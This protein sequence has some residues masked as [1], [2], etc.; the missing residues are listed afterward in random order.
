MYIVA[1]GFLAWAWVNVKK[2]LPRSIIPL[3]A[4]ISSLLL[5]VQIFEFPVAGGGS[6]WHFLGG[7]TVSM[8]LGPYAGLIS[9]TITLIIQAIALGDGGLTSFGANVFNMAVIGALSFFI[10]RAVLLR[11]FSTKRLALGVFAASFISNFCTALAVGL[12]IG[13]FPMVGNLGGVGVTVSSM[14][15]WY[16]P[17]GV[18]EGIVASALVISLSKLGGVK[19]FG[20]ECCKK[21]R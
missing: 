11:G 13:L 10:V 21:I 5:V 1:F 4:V 6:T 17:T 19:L 9:M 14:L 18:V 12:E 8:I 16:V 7:T 15:V 20:L 3:I 2:T